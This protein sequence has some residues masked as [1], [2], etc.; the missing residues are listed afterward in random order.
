VLSFRPRTTRPEL[1][2][3]L[4]SLCGELTPAGGPLI[5]VQ[6]A[7]PRSSR[8]I[9]MSGSLGLYFSAMGGFFLDSTIRS[10]MKSVRRENHTNTAE[11]WPLIDA[12]ISNSGLGAAPSRP[13]VTY[14][15][16]VN[17]ETWYGSCVG[18]PLRDTDVEK[19]RSVLSAVPSL[20][21]RYDRS[22]PAKSRVLNRDNPRL[23]FEIDHDP[24]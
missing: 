8:P 21:V 20:Y 18:F 3:A 12:K 1:Q 5:L 23:P 4:A 6:G 24:Y 16:V 9:A 10:I 19:A 15:Y 7:T 11:N 22:D 2:G 17:G 14:S 13:G